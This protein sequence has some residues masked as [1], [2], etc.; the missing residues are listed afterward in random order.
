MTHSREH[1]GKLFKGVV[2]KSF[3]PI[4]SFYYA[5]SIGAITPRR[6]ESFT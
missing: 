2:A 1:T 3:V 5:K 4:E 6:P